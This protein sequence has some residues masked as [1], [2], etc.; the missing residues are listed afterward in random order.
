MIEWTSDL[1]IVGWNAA[2]A[3]LFSFFE[4]E[5]LGERIDEL[6]AIRQLAELSHEDWTSCDR[7]GVLREHVGISGKK[8][9]RW[10]NTPFMVKGARISTLSTIIDTTTQTAI[11]NEELRSQLQS[12][13]QVLKH[14]TARLQ[15]AISDRAQTYAALS[16]S[17]SRFQSIAATMPGV[18]YQFCLQADGQFTIPYISTTAEEV[19]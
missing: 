6:L 18:L 7:A 16:E 8:L 1:I 17:E 2:A 11:S 5:A 10:F 9:C 14:T 4:E 15:T 13:T 12:R 19:Y 3:E